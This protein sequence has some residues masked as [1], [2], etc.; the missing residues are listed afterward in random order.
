MLRIRTVVVSV[1]TVLIFSIALPVFAVPH[2]DGEWTYGGHHDPTN[3]G[4]FSNYYHRSNYHWFYVGS[5]V[6]NNKKKSYAVAGI[7]SYAFINTYIGEH[8]LFDAGF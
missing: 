2:R 8:V 4:A 6:R 5:N 7:H 1:I 3:W